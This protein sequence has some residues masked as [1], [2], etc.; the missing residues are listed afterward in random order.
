MHRSIPRRCCSCLLL[1]LFL[2]LNLRICGN[3]FIKTVQGLIVRQRSKVIEL[4]I[5]FDFR[6]RHWPPGKST[7]PTVA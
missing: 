1:A 6:P 2:D 4:E 3:I 7:P 5:A